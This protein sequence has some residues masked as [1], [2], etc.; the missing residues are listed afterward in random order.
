MAG[1]N[2]ELYA[3]LTGAISTLQSALNSSSGSNSNR[4]RGVQTD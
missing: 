3:A 2:N 1:M 4:A